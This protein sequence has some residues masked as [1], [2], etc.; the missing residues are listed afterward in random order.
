MFQFSF[1][2]LKKGVSL[3]Y[4]PTQK[5]RV[6]FTPEKVALFIFVTFHTGIKNCRPP[7]LLHLVCKSYL[8][9][10]TVIISTARTFLLSQQERLLLR[11]CCLRNLKLAL[12]ASMFHFYWSL[13]QL[14]SRL[15]CRHSPLS[16]LP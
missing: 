13:R 8:L 12:R 7:R 6:F 3:T 2:Y 9:Y 11:T 14:H 4:I 15:L 5:K 1:Q 16:P 10:T